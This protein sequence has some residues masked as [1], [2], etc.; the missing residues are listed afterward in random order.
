MAR[1]DCWRLLGVSAD[2]D[3]DAVRAA[4]TRR[5]RDVHPD[6]GGTGDSLTMRLLVEARDEALL[7]VA[8][9]G[10]T[11]SATGERPRPR[12]QASAGVPP[13]RCYSCGREVPR[14]GQAKRSRWGGLRLRLK[15]RK[16]PIC[17]A[18]AKQRRAYDP[19]QRNR[20]LL[21]VTLA[22]STVATIVLVIY[23]LRML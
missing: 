1:I 21:L 18:C 13:Q 8:G 9:R 20:R 3:A 6:G 5:A 12:P 11:S 23:M 16:A 7:L 2:A 17:A 14:E 22:V 15:G 19:E 4:F 10:R